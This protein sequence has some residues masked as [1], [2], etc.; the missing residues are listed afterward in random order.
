M[1]RIVIAVVFFAVAASAQITNSD[2]VGVWKGTSLC[3]VKPSPCHD[4]TVVYHFTA[5]AEK[6]GRLKLSADKIVNG[7]EEW[8]GDLD[9]DVHAEKS[10]IT[11]DIKGRPV[12]QF[13]VEGDAMSGTLVLEDGTLYRKIEVKRQ[14]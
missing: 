8:M 4:E 11:C 14:K 10:T 6:K 5:P 1:S 7:K 9:C 12:W 3:T 2:V 13:A